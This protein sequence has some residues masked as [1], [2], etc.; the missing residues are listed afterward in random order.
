MKMILV[1]YNKYYLE[2]ILID[3]LRVKDD[4]YRQILLNNLIDVKNNIM[5]LNR[6]FVD[7]SF[8]E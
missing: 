6:K 5:I 8:N 3:S 2:K 1:F 4:L 7:L